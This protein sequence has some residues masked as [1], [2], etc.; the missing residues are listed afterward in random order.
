MVTEFLAIN[1]HLIINYDVLRKI[2]ELDEDSG[3]TTGYEP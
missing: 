3:S 2:T 1:F